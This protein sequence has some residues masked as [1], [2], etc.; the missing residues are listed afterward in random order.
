VSDSPD[1]V[2][3]VGHVVPATGPLKPRSILALSGGGMYGAYTVGV[4]N[5]WSKVGNRPTFDV[6]TGISTGALIA[7]LAFLGLEHDPHLTR[8]YTSITRRD[9]FA[10][11]SW[12]TLPF[13][14][15]VAT[16]APLKENVAATITED[17]VLALA[18]EHRKGRR[19]YIGTTNLDTKR[20]ITWDLGAIAAE[21]GKPARK[22][23]IDL[24][25]ASC[26]LPGV[27]SPVPIDVELDGKRYT[28]LHIDGGM[29]APV[30][31]PTQVMDAAALDP[32]VPLAAQTPATLYVVLAGKAFTDP[33]PTPARLLPVLGAGATALISAQT[34]R[35]VS[36]LYHICRLN[37]IRFQMSALAADFP[38]PAGGLDFDR[39]EMNKLYD[40]GFRIGSSG[41]LWWAA[42]PERG[43][44]EIDPIR[45][46]NRFQSGR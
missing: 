38:T 14:D 15:A 33:A 41:P 23:I 4:L 42:P 18:A 27:F 35:E 29:T 3:Q 22:L 28:E 39:P 46:G 24:M 1:G 19:L 2:R 26:S 37:G 34:R 8:S 17:I 44:G 25:V 30:F 31:V 5:G 6:V 11:R 10:Y 7:P 40:E 36:N 43:T 45:T 20:F 21:G 13:R 32:T 16:T 12:A 9:V